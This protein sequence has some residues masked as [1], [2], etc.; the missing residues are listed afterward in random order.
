MESTTINVMEKQTDSRVRDFVAL[1][2]PRVM[3]LVVFS[4]VVGL[5]V[6]GLAGTAL[7]KAALRAALLTVW[8]LLNAAL[9]VL[10]AVDG[11]LL[12]A[13]P[14]VLALAPVLVVGLVLGEALHRRLDEQVFRRVVLLLL[15]GT[16]VAL[17]VGG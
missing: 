13:L 10:Y 7:G 4:G 14:R 1:L 5:L 9:T 17:L 6:A 15:A 8:L 11:S 2:K 12:P 3:T 16:G